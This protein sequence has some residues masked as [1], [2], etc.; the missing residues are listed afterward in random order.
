MIRDEL[1]LPRLKGPDGQ[2]NK[3]W[4]FLTKINKGFSSIGFQVA[5][6]NLDGRRAWSVH[7]LSKKA[8][9]KIEIKLGRDNA[10]DR[11]ARFVKVF[12]SIN[13]FDL[14]GVEVIDL[15]YPNGFAMRIKN[16]IASKHVLVM[17]V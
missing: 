14:K 15:R 11:L 9:T 1:N 5:D 3:V 10:T 12:S 6:L 7:F 17:E 8:A 4:L 13:K 16:N 2:H